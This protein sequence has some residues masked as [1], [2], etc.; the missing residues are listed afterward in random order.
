[1]AVLFSP[2]YG[3]VFG[4]VGA[5]YFFVEVVFM[6]CLGSVGKFWMD[7]CLE[8][9]VSGSWLKEFGFEYVIR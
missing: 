3:A 7:E 6:V 4:P 8:V 5:E 9:K 1:M 2:V